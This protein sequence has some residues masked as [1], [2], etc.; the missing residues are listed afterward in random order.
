MRDE[1]SVLVFQSNENINTVQL[2]TVDEKSIPAE[3]NG[4]SGFHIYHVSVK[5]FQYL[6]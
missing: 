4:E 1:N 2:Q 3:L 5:I 6:S